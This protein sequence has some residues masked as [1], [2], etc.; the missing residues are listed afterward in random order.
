[1]DMHKKTWEV[2]ASS[3]SEV[4]PEKR[5]NLFA[6]SLDPEFLYTDPMTVTLHGFE[7]LSG[8]MDQFQSL[9]PGGGFEITD[10]EFHHDK[11]IASWNLIDADKKVISSGKSFARYSPD[12][13]I[14]EEVGFFPVPKL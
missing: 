3:W 9:V 6:Q 5:K 13:K 1:M 8:Y 12:G 2:Y 11:S 7:A 4:D 10:Y 14:L